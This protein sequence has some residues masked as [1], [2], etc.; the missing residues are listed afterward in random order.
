MHQRPYYQQIYQELSRDQAM[1]FLAGARQSGK[2]TFAQSMA[3]RQAQFIYANWDIVADKKKI[4]ANPVFF[5]DINRT[6]R[7]KP[8]V[9]LDEIHKYR[10]WK[11]YLKGIYDQCHADYE[12]LILGSGRLDVFQKGGDSLAGRYRL[13]H[14]FPLTIAEL[15]GK[16]TD[17]DAFYR[18]PL[19]IH[20]SSDGLTALWGQLSRLSG[21][22]DPFFSATQKK[23]RRWAS[24]YAQQL[25]REDIRNMT[26]IKDIDSVESLYGLLGTR[27]G[28]PLSISNLANDLGVSFNAVKEWLEIFERF[29]LIFRISPWTLKV[30]R[31]ILKEQKMYLYDYAQIDDEA[32]RFENMTALE[33]WRAVCHWNDLGLG[34]FTLHY[35][36]NKEKQEVDFVVADKNK[37]FLFIETKLTATQISSHLYKFQALF[38][39]PVVQLV[40]T[41]G[42]CQI[43][44][45]GARKILVIT[46][47]QWLARLP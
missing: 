9:I 6:G 34:K 25:I 3:R 36:R 17:F 15:A 20:P 18:D 38:D 31:A 43:K 2:T 27:V 1:I 37:P 13:L 11:N 33:L 40:Y 8:L 7:E 30:A 4:L 22:P 14:F 16:Q 35:I 29:Y 44:N 39:V 42:I 45:N 26:L 41:P 46:A 10:H 32:A 23:Y 19:A 21:F 12:F 5:Q 28:N 24:I 47:S